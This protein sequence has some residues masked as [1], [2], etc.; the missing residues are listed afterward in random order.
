VQSFKRADLA[1]ARQVRG[2]ID[3]RIDLAKAGAVLRE[4]TGLRVKA[5]LRSAGPADA[6]VLDPGAI[7]ILVA[8]ASARTMLV[9]VE[10]AL[11]IALVGGA[12]K[13]PRTRIV[14]A[15]RAATPQLAGAAGALLVACARRVSHDA[16]LRVVSCG[17]A[18]AL[19]AEAHRHDPNRV[20]ATFLV[21][22]EDDV[23][24]AR[25]SI[26]RSLVG[27]KM[28]ESADAPFDIA[29]LGATPISI[30]L[31]AAVSV[32]PRGEIESLRPGDAWLP[33]T[34]TLAPSGSGFTGTVV[35]C[36]PAGERGVGAKVDGSKCVLAD[37]DVTLVW[38]PSMDGKDALSESM[39]D[40]PI[41]V[42]VEVGTAQMPAREWAKLG[43]GDVVTLGKRIGEHVVLRVAGE[44]VARG[45][46]V[47][48]EG[49]IGVRIVSR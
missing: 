28:A 33:G 30:P 49:E 48:V 32:A 41:V 18:A 11:A 15:A 14:D 24:V 34:F 40:V 45:E 42:R 8:D 7:G 1:A 25:A 2:W 44:E 12:L 16:P 29:A 6:R 20:A 26:P 9:E 36:A 47:E 38:E 17:S 19:W 21:Y 23:H 4:M 35:L 43:A 27:E 13:R 22:A 46:L 37:E 10:A 31:V 39:G 3:S 5:N